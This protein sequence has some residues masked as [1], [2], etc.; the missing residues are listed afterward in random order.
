MNI[1][2]PHQLDTRVKLNIFQYFSTS[3]EHVIRF[4]DHVGTLVTASVIESGMEQLSV[5]E[6]SPDVGNSKPPSLL[7]QLEERLVAVIE[8][9]MEKVEEKIEQKM[10]K[11]EEKME[12]KMEKIEEKI[13]EKMEK[14]E[15]RR[16][17]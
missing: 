1:L 7:S 4:L 13:E 5:T 17:L 10:E 12:E 9:K 3:L 11:V 16:I 8:E 6:T 2:V 14:M 15:E